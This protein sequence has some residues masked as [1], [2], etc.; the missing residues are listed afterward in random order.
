MNSLLR[1]IF[2]LSFVFVLSC[3][4]TGLDVEQIRDDRM[5]EGC[6]TYSINATSYLKMA[7]GELCKTICTPD[8]PEN[9]TYSYDRNGC[10]V[11]ITNVPE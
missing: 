6:I 5:Q 10:E 7:S 1:V 2:F 4:G 3:T 8:L 9:F 11:N